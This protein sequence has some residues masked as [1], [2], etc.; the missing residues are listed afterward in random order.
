MFVDKHD[1]WLYIQLNEILWLSNE[2]ALQVPL[3]T[4][5]TTKVGSTESES[6]SVQMSAILSV[7]LEV[8]YTKR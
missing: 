1:G 6:D 7:G 2:T 4:H 8:T 5:G 3:M